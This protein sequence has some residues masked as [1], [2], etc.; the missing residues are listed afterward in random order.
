[1]NFQPSHPRLRK[2]ENHVILIH[3]LVDEGDK[4]PHDMIVRIKLPS[5]EC[6]FGV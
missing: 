4:T 3:K 6:H 1:M 2:I 5:L